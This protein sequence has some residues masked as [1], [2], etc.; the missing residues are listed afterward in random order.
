M[1]APLRAVTVRDAIFDL[2]A[3][4]N[5]HQVDSISHP[6]SSRKSA[7]QRFI[8]G[9]T[10]TTLSDHICKEMNELNLERCK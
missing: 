7:Y 6:A 4:S 8:Q 9:K 5:G 10:D 1:G 3:I 2:P